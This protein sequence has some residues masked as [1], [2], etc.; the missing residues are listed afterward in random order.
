MNK[1][2]AINLIKNAK[3]RNTRVNSDGTKTVTICV[4][5]IG[6]IAVFNE[7]KRNYV[8]VWFVHLNAAKARV[9]D[10]LQ[11]A[12]A[13]ALDDFISAFKL[14]SDNIEVSYSEVLSNEKRY[15]TLY[16]KQTGMLCQ[17]VEGTRNYAFKPAF[18][19]Y[20]QQGFDSLTIKKIKLA[21]FI[22]ENA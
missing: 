3:Y 9:V 5:G 12:Y 21:I 10:N 16:N 18:Q 8:K 15:Y 11:Q 17:Y 7:T 4:P 14:Q 22:F 13:M 20:W 2:V 1:F 6:E 19:N